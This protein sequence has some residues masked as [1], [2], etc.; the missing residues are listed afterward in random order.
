MI[1][2]RPISDAP[3]D[4][5]RVL[6]LHRLWKNAMTAYWAGQDWILSDSGYVV[7]IPPTH[8]AYITPPEQTR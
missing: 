6:C 3:K 4:G 2:W 8:F 5:T 7:G 1:D